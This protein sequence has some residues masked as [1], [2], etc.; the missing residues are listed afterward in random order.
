MKL[1]HGTSQGLHLQVYKKFVSFQ[2][3]PILAY[4]FIFF[5][6]SEQKETFWWD[7]CCVPNCSNQQ[8]K[9]LSNGD[10]PDVRSQRRHS[11]LWG[12]V[13]HTRQALLGKCVIHRMV[14]T[15]CACAVAHC[16]FHQRCGMST[17]PFSPKRCR[18]QKCNTNYISLCTRG[19]LD[20]F[21]CLCKTAS[22][23]HTCGKTDDDEPRLWRCR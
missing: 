23:P 14:T 20:P 2:N 19:H 13:R 21:S 16:C 22:V 15:F 4:K 11:I 18:M 12:N 5:D 9:R 6:S 8:E 17:T 3:L 1:F 7:F 10:R